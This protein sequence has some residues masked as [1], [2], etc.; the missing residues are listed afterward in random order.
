MIPREALHRLKTARRKVVPLFGGL[1][2]AGGIC[3]VRT[4]ASIQTPLL[5]KEGMG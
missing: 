4:G 1:Y 5:F 2:N 3:K